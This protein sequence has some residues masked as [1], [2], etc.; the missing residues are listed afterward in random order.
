M[1]T[2]IQSPS[3]WRNRRFVALSS[4]QLLSAFGSWL[5]ILAVFVLIGI[6][7]HDGPLAV[8]F[9]MV[10]LTAPT[11]AVRPYAGALADR[12]D[13]RRLMMGSNVLSGLIVTGLFF[14]HTLWELYVGL[15]LLGLTD[16][17]FSP[18][19]SGMLKEIVPDAQMGQAMS[20]RMV[21]SQGTKILGPSI[22]GVLVALFGARIP[23]AVDVV[24]FVLSTVIILF[25]AGGRAHMQAE[26]DGAASNQE[27]PRYTDG[28]RYLW[29]N[30]TLRGMVLFLGLMLLVL[31]MSDAQ[32]VTLL[33]HVPHASRTLGLAMSASG[34]GMAL[35]A[36]FMGRV[37]ADRAL[38]WMALGSTGMGVAYAGSAL[39]VVHGL[40]VGVPPLILLGGAA[41]ASA[42]VPF[43][44]ALQR[45]VPVAWTGRVIA[46]VGMVTSSVVVLG[47]I[48]GGILMK[49]VGVVPI[50][51]I[52]G[53]TLC[54]L[55]LVV[56]VITWTRGRMR[57]AQGQ[58]DL[59]RGTTDPPGVGG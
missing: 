30:P 43:E 47:P 7:W 3:L 11:M 23:F 33:K 31:Q 41:A 44:T 59:Q 48:L 40:P 49:L 2:A 55:G 29:G 54:V 9:A 14:V 56:W 22:S 21:I 58:R 12:Q 45:S 38:G 17:F 19:E 36:V 37:H 16:S 32:F 5:L 8:A 53:S 39:L 51:L 4:A 10:V 25:I 34:L 35:A 24:A 50:F 1:D 18:A 28:F 6:R 13:R 42:M 57:D 46:T 27:R 52:N 20:V 15:A 26:P